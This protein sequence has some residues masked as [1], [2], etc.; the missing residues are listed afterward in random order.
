MPVLCVV[1]TLVGSVDKDIGKPSP[2]TQLSH[3]LISLPFKFSCSI[4]SS[5]VCQA[6]GVGAVD[7]DTEILKHNTCFQGG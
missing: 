1:P 6:L 7:K 2:H 5:F 4:S 3:I